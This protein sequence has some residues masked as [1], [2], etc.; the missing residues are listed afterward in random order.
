[1][2]IRLNQKDTKKAKELAALLDFDQSTIM[3]Q[4]FETGLKKFS[5]ETALALYAEEKLS[6]SEAAGL[7][8][9]PVGQFMETLIKRGI[10]QEM[11]KELLEEAI[12]NAKKLISKNW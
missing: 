6:L 10:R 5:Q 3:R 1:M 8:E 4:A 12:E 2:S 9:Q 7:A 11:P